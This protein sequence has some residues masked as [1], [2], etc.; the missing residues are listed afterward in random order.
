MIQLLF[1]I[2]VD[3]HYLEVPL[4]KLEPLEQHHFHN[5]IKLLQLEQIT[6]VLLDHL[7]LVVVNHFLQLQDQLLTIKV[8]NLEFVFTHCCKLIA[9]NLPTTYQ[10]NYICYLKCRWLASYGHVARW[11]QIWSVQPSTRTKRKKTKLSLIRRRSK[12]TRSC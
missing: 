4:V 10:S 7:L 11:K 12:W 8:S 5:Q 6:T 2:Q 3:H 9:L 1:N